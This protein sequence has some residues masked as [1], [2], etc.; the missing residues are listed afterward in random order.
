MTT[1]VPAIYDWAWSGFSLL[2]L[3]GVVVLVVRLLERWRRRSL[4]RSA[5]ARGQDRPSGLPPG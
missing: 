2:V 3:G 5:R 1:F 4:A